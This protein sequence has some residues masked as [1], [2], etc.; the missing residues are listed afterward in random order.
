MLESVLLP[1]ALAYE[2]RMYLPMVGPAVALPWLLLS[3]PRMPTRLAAA[4]GLVSVALL[5]L[6]TLARNDL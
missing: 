1:V 4:I 5:G 3:V 2:H 6:A